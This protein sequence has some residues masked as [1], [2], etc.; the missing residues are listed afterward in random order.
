MFSIGD[1]IR[2]KYPMNGNT[3]YKVIGVNY[4]PYPSID[5]KL[6]DTTVP[7]Y[8]YMIGRIYKNQLAD[9]YILVRRVSRHHPLT[10]VFKDKK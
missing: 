10:D 4:E 1:K 6:V 5:I 8:Q 7:A 9:Y 2:S 3:L